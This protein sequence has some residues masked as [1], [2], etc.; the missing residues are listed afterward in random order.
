MSFG[1]VLGHIFEKQFMSIGAK[2]V[3][4]GLVIGWLYHSIMSSR[5]SRGQTIGKFMTNLSVRQADGKCLPV[6]KSMVRSFPLV[7][8]FFGEGFNK[9]FGLDKIILVKNLSDAI[10]LSLIIGILYLLFFNLRTNQSLH[11][12]IFGTAVDST[13]EVG[14]TG[15][16]IW[17]YHYLIIL[18]IIVLLKAGTYLTQKDLSNQVANGLWS[19]EFKGMGKATKTIHESYPGINIKYR[20]DKDGEIVYITIQ[21]EKEANDQDFGAVAK[22]ISD[23]LPFSSEDT[24]VIITFYRGYDIGI[25]RCHKIEKKDFI[26][27]ELESYLKS[28]QGI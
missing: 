22:I 28:S 10:G 3:L 1:F 14:A 12:L 19:Q 15:D 20:W 2:G 13:E 21:S 17:K 26:A 11:D 7:F 6:W 5:L 9:T 24:R 8:V 18:I 27:K 16:T 25:Y 23:D 4:F